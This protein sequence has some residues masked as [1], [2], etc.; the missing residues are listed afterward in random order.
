MEHNDKIGYVSIQVRI[1]NPGEEVI[2]C[3]Q[4]SDDV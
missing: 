4:S 1:A 3:G 2:G